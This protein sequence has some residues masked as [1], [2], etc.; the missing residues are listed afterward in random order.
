MPST[1][2]RLQFP[3]AYLVALALVLPLGC[4]G[5]G[6]R[7][8]NDP[9][10]DGVANPNNGSN[11]DDAVTCNDSD[12]SNDPASSHKVTICHFPPGN[13]ANAHTIRVGAAAVPAHLA[14]GDHLGPCGPGE[15]P[16]GHDGGQQDGGD[17]HDG[18]QGGQPDG[19]ASCLPRD[20]SCGAGTAPCCSG[21][22]CVSNVCVPPLP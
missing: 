12:S 9:L 22:L 11:S 14:H 18:G 2:C 15:G 1:N 13:P 5:S 7:A 17:P 8:T 4:G 21:L 3:I 10:T 16:C 20:A 6:S 19:G